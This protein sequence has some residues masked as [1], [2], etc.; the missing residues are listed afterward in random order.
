[1]KVYHS[2]RVP[3]TCFGQSY[4]NLQG[5]ASQRIHRNIT[6]VFRPN[7]QIPANIYENT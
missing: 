1:M 5:G 6:E 3:A 4:G 2:Q 7:V